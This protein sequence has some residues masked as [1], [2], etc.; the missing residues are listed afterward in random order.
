LQGKRFAVS[1]VSAKIHIM[2]DSTAARRSHEILRAT[3]G[4]LHDV[5]RRRAEEIYVRN[6]RI[7][8]RDVQNWIQAEQEVLR[9][10]AERPSRRTAIVVN[11]EGV[12]YIGEY[13]PESAEGYTPGEFSTGEPVSVRFQDEYM[14][15]QLPNGRELKTTIVKH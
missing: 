14:Y 13:N 1:L 10:A 3:L 11:V 9:E 6:G 2:E 15:V 12:Q 8:G 4:Q 5:I 7:P